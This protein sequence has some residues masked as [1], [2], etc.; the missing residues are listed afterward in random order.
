LKAEVLAI[1]KQIAAGATGTLSERI[2]DDGRISEVRAR[3]Y[4]G[5]ERAL[6]VKPYIL[7]KAQRTEDMFTYVEG[8]EEFLS[9][10]DDTFTF[11]VSV[12]V[13]Y[14]DELKVWYQNTSSFE[15]TLVL[16]IVI[17]YTEGEY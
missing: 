5:Q 11:P 13:Q 1:R 9:G 17:I 8:S 7:H 2:K 12:G 6:R 15:Y 14:D 16:D 3:F 10:D 4:A